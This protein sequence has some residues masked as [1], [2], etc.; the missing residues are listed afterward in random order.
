MFISALLTSLNAHQV[1]KN[2]TTWPIY[3]QILLWLKP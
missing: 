2:T 1:N 3:Y